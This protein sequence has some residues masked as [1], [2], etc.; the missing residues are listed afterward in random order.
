[1]AGSAATVSSLT[2]GTLPDAQRTPGAALPVS[3]QEICT[4]HYSQRVRH[5]PAIVKRQIYA[6]YRRRRA[7]GLC[8]ELDHLIPLE[9]GGSNQQQNLWPEPYDIEWNAQVK[10]RLEGK[11][12]RMVCEGQ[13]P[14]T[15]AQHAIAANWVDAYR[16]YVGPEPMRSVRKRRRANKHSR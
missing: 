11:L 4:P 2:P 5:V 15:E 8:C 1:M 9:L 6:E 14:L 10:D 12:H 16:Q 7:Q 3:V 13:L